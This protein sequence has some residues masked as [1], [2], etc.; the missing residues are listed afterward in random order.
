MNV[1]PSLVQQFAPAGAL[2]ASLNMGNP[3]LAHSRTSTDKPAGVS[4]DLARELAR[5]LGVPARL[6]EF[7]AAA[8]SVEVL[9]AGGADIGFMAIDPLRADSIQFTAPSICT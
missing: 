7:P 8:K 5:E 3:V 4:I 6:L 2:R 1:T 9:A